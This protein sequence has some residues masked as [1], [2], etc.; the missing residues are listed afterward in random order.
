MLVIEGNRQLRCRSNIT[1]FNRT[2][3]KSVRKIQNSLT[4]GF[5]KI[6]REF[7]T[8]VDKFW[9]KFDNVVMALHLRNPPCKVNRSTALLHIIFSVSQNRAKLKFTTLILAKDDYKHKCFGSFWF[10]INN[11][12][13]TTLQSWSSSLWIVI[14]NTCRLKTL[15]TSKNA[16]RKILF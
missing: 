12:S 13:T 6:W 4:A 16:D 2:L 8:K 15:L 11:V 10:W 1:L 9:S 5:S 3:A 14:F 7:L